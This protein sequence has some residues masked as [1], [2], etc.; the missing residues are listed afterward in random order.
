MTQI[1]VI[2]TF[3][4]KDGEDFS[5]STDAIYKTFEDAIDCV[6]NNT[7]DIAEEGYNQY[8]LVGST[9]FGCYPI[10]NEIHWFKWDKLAK[11]YVMVPRPSF[12]SIWC[13]SL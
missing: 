9:T 1:Y 7:G 3:H 10:I 5:S 11:E 2:K 13:F 12:T 8:V 4:L 6:L